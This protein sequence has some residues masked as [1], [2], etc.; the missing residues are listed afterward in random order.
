GL[1]A[2]R[3]PYPCRSVVAGGYHPPAIGAEARF[4]YTT[5]VLK[6]R[7]RLAGGR[8]PDSGRVVPARRNE[9]AAVRAEGDVIEPS[10][11]KDARG[12]GRSGGRIPYLRGLHGCRGDAAA[13]G[14]E[15]GG[16]HYPGTAHDGGAWPARH[17][18]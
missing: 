2:R 11:A 7:D 3:I 16:D 10:D 5:C 12:D 17:R 6:N 4:T 9:A 18:I 8:V 14:T 1:A 15:S 13:I